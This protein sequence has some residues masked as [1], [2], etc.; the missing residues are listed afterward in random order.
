[1]HDACCTP[2]PNANANVDSGPTRVLNSFTHMRDSIS[3]AG[4]RLRR[5]AFDRILQGK[6]AMLAA[7]NAELGLRDGELG[8]A[9]QELARMGLLTRDASGREVTGSMGLTKV[10]TKHRLVLRD[11]TLFTWCALDAIGISAGQRLDAIVESATFD[12]GIAVRLRIKQGQPV[13]EANPFHIRVPATFV[14]ERIRETVCPRIEFWA[15][16]AAS[17][18]KDLIAITLPEAAELGQ[19]LWSPPPDARAGDGG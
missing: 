8:E 3:P 13:V 14:G 4:T 12:G 6:P 2:M 19:A 17:G 11:R 5:W 1:M 18:T 9:L 10:P 15:G 7:A 16:P